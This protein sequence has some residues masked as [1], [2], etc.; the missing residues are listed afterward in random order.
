[1][2]GVALVLVSYNCCKTLL[3]YNNCHW[4]T[5]SCPGMLSH[6]R[7]TSSW[8]SMTIM[9]TTRISWCPYSSLRVSCHFF[10]LGGVGKMVNLDLPTYSIAIGFTEF[11][12]S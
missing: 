2:K 7:L 10:V 6:L 9:P 11:V 4:G 12:I 1:M 5:G 3:V 8:L